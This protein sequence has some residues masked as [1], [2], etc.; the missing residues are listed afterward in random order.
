MMMFFASY[1]PSY[2]ACDAEQ[3][4]QYSEAEAQKPQQIV[5]RVFVCEGVSFEANGDTITALSTALLT[6]VTVMLMF[7]AGEQTR[8]SRAELRGYVFA[9]MGP[10]EI[11]VGKIPTM[12]VRTKNYGTTP[13]RKLAMTGMIT[14]LDLPIDV[15]TMNI[16]K[17]EPP[18]FTLPPGEFHK[19][20]IEG[21]AKLT[22]GD[23]K[24]IA[25]GKCALF[26][27]GLII[28]RDAFGE[29]RETRF[30]WVWKG[31]TRADGYRKITHA[32][33][34]NSWT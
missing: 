18:E 27:T 6:V 10:V 2:K 13:V 14:V 34:G 1:S 29:R 12:D 20:R 22:E 21:T 31:V 8:T 33:R 4:K 16:P 30:S 23:L 9:E 11:E 25:D 5:H 24:S 19:L 17:E 28:Y 15:A 3:R 26:F 7:L 32:D